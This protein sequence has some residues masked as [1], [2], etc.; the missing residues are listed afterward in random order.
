LG[1]AKV[2]AIT[3]QSEV[4][5]AN[6][7]LGFAKRKVE[8]L[9]SRAGPG[10]DA[11]KLGIQVPVDEV[12]FFPTLPLRVTEVKRAQ[13]EEV[14]GPVMTVTS[15]R[16]VID[17]ALSPGDAKLVR[18]GAPVTIRVPDLGVDATGTVTQVATSPGTNGVD[19]Q[20][21]YMEVTPTGIADSLVGASVVQTIIVQSTE[22]EV[23]TVPVAAL[24]V[25][26]D[27]STRVQVQRPGGPPVS[28]AVTP[29]LTA[30]GLVGVT[31][32]QGGLAPGDFVVVGT[33]GGGTGPGKGRTPASGRPADRK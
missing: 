1:D 7:S 27:G 8:L 10:P 26:A 4:D 17:S 14:V 29:G 30:K 18:Q 3:A 28:V 24:S 19:P 11:T 23:L 9:S 20:R 32:V 12:L 5:K 6:A 22:G 13:G 15:S 31:P 16:L 33:E 21:F 2:E 25:A